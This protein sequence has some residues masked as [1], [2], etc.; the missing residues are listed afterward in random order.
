MFAVRQA[1]LGVV[2]D[3]YLT[4]TRVRGGMMSCDVTSEIG[5]PSAF[6]ILRSN[7]DSNGWR[8]RQCAVDQL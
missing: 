7:A 5:E 2:H 8:D 4:V 3:G 6:Y 1:V